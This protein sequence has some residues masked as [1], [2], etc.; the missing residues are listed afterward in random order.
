MDPLS[1]VY[2][3]GAGPGDPELLTLKAARLLKEAEVVVYD[4]LVSEEILDLIP[5]GTTRI[6]AGKAARDHFMPQDEINDQLVAIAK[7]NRMAVRLKGGDPFI[8][9]RGSEE[10]LFLADNNVPFEIV[11]GI[12]ASAG[13]GS[14]AGIPLT[15]RG[16]ATGVRFVTGHCR[17]GKH[18]DLN[19]Q[20]LADPDTT[21]VIYMG[22]I[23]I[24]LIRD[25]LIK[26]GLPA[27]TP[28]GAIEKGTTPEQR[29][30]LTTLEELPACIEK[31][32]LKAPS[33]LIIGRV[34]ELAGE[35]S[36]H[37][38]AMDCDVEALG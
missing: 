25:E 9:G 24:A 13:C 14:Y 4:R 6:F 35:L 33:L 30:I 28:A 23:N 26:A 21:L 5:S 37:I 1:T 8:F 29:T 11:P 20:S 12:T 10:A 15:H 32:D 17:E 31:A 19:W 18:L 16:M 22:L 2:I 3:V 7:S 38:P 36:W 34:V 27:D